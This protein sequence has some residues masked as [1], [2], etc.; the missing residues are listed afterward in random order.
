M[1]EKFTVEKYCDL[2]ASEQPAP[3]G[4]SALALIGA[5]ACSLIEMSINVTLEKISE[6][7]DLYAYLTSE[8][9]S[10]KRARTRMLQLSD[11][12]AQVYDGIVSARKLPKN[13]EEESKTRTAALQKAFHKATLVPLE[14]MSLSLDAAKKACSRVLSNVTKYVRSDCEIGVNLLK[15]VAKDCVKNV[16]GNTCFIHDETLKNTLNRQAAEILTEINKL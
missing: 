2:L 5:I 12:D 3:G 11:D 7:D 16:E 6:T 8:R 4:G 15:T 14:V 10:L 9:N 13:T 1:F